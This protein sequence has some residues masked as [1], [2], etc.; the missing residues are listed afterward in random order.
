MVLRHGSSQ[1]SAKEIN[2]SELRSKINLI[3]DH[4][5]R[6]LEIGVVEIAEDQDYYWDSA[7][8]SASTNRDPP[9]PDVGR[10][11]DDLEFLLMLSSAEESPSL[12]LMHVAPLLRYLAHR[13]GQ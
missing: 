8:A 6:N 3:F 5:E 7:F 11:R 1:M 13:L 2:I 10:L 9:A 4:I 12:M